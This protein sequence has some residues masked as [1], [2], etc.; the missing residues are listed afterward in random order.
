MGQ[1]KPPRRLTLP[2]ARGHAPRPPV[3][4]RRGGRR[5][6]TRLRSGKIVSLEGRF[7]IECQFHDLADGGARIRP[8]GPY[9]LPDRFWLFDDH[10]RNVAYAEVAWRNGSGIGVSFE[11]EPD[12]VALSHERIAHLA[13][14]YY[15]L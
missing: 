10:E 9:R 6:R 13:R 4:E 3:P 5:F 15:G 12:A 7:L 14:K 8:V 2:S 1:G 11:C